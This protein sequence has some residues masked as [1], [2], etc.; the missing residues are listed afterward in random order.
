MH[1]SE[2]E[3]A[4][5]RNCI[6]LVFVGIASR[7][8]ANRQIKSADRHACAFFPLRFNP[9]RQKEKFTRYGTCTRIQRMEKR[10][11]RRRNWE[12]GPSAYP[13]STVVFDF[14]SSSSVW[15]N[16]CLQTSSSVLYQRDKSLSRGR[17]LSTFLLRAGCFPRLWAQG[18]KTRKGTVWNEVSLIVL[19]FA[20]ENTLKGWRT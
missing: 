13:S 11:R 9:T 6:L 8:A 10:G 12:T 5:Y 16:W 18:R 4:N 14:S 7:P 20:L 2:T 3:L 19:R 1:E 17:K 15:Q